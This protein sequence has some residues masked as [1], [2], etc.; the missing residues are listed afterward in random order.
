[1]TTKNCF[2]CGLEKPIEQ[3]PFRHKS[4]NTQH[5]RCKQCLCVVRTKYQPNKGPRQCSDVMQRFYSKVKIVD[6]G[7]WEWQGGL[8]QQG[9][10]RFAIK[11]NGVWGM[12]LAHR[13]IY[14]I[15]NNTELGDLNACHKCDNPKC[16]NPDHIFAGT[17]AD[18]INDAKIKGRIHSG[19]NH[20][21]NIKP[22]IVKRGND[23]WSVQR[24]HDVQRDKNGKFSHKQCLLTDA[25]L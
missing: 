3:F 7:C 23:H 1:M 10:P 22:H 17:Q 2:D 14:Q 4:K 20:Y 11:M 6:S 18:N 5:N 8:T 13:F 9:Y 16:V 24:P 19:E 12:V 25:P 15:A 21:S